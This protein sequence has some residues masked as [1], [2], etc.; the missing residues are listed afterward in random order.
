MRLLK[1]IA[2][3]MLIHTVCKL[4][5]SLKKNILFSEAGVIMNLDV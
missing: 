1:R 2:K 3:A 5:N 4:D